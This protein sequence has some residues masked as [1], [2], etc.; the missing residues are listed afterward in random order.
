MDASAGAG[1]LAVRYDEQH[2]V[3]LEA[4]GSG[5]VTAV[6]ARASVAGLAQSWTPTCPAGDVELRIEMA[7]AGDRVHAEALGGDRIR[8]VAPRGRRRLLLAELDGRYWTAETCASFTGRVVGLYATEGTVDLRRLPLPGIR[9]AAGCLDD[10]TRGGRWRSSSPP[11]TSHAAPYIDVEVWADF[12]CGGE[13]AA[14]AGLLGRRGPWRCVRAAA[15]RRLAPGCRA[16][17]VD[18]AGLA[19][20]DRRDR[21]CDGP[22][23][24]AA[25]LRA[26][27]LADVAVRAQP[28]PCRRHARAAGGRHR[29][30]AALAGHP[31]EVASLRRATGRPRASTRRC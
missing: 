1:G 9:A 5:G 8:L 22:T 4:R 15:L 26:R 19:G 30:G 18:D 21:A 3:A 11:S 24:R 28:G 29:L 12:A 16:A 31:E 25:R 23:R 13:R 14:P 27:L 7:P 20:R 6:T 10:E 2:H 17:S